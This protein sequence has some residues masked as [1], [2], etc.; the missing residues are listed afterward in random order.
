LLSSHDLRTSK[1]LIAS[2]LLQ[3]VVRRPHSAATYE[4]RVRRRCVMPTLSPWVIAH[5]GYR[6][7]Y[8]VGG[9]V[10]RSRIPFP[11][12]E[13]DTVNQSTPR[14]LLMVTSDVDAFKENGL[15]AG[16]VFAVE[17]GEYGRVARFLGS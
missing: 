4:R 7:L 1:T 6:T 17:V 8:G 10:R 16:R 5:Q 11:S 9:E 14:H 12:S 15:I 13:I 3:Y 2:S